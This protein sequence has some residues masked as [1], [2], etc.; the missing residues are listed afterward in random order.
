MDSALTDFL[1]SR[2]I[3]ARQ[4]EEDFL[5]R[6]EAAARQLAEQQQQEQSAGGYGVPNS[7]AASRR[8][9]TRNAS[10]TATATTPAAG[11]RRAAAKKKTA[12]Q[13]KK[14]KAEMKRKFYESDGDDDDDDD[15]DDDL[16][17]ALL[18]NVNTPLPGQM[19]NCAQCGKRFTVTPYSRADASGKLLC[20]PCGKEL[21]KADAANGAKGG[22]P[23]KKP[24]PAA[25][26]GPV[27]QR[28][29]AQSRLLDG[30]SPVG[31]KALVTLCVEHLSRN[32]DLADN[33][34]DLPEEVVDS[35]ARMLSKRRLLNPRTI[36]LFA[37][38][39]TTVLRVYDGAD[40]L[41]NDFMRIL[42][43]MPRLKSLTVYNAI[44][45]KDPVMDYLLT[46]DL[47]LDTLCLYGANLLSDAKWKQ[48]LVERGRHLRTLT[49]C[50]T[51]KHLTDEV[52]QYVRDCA[53]E[54]TKLKICGNEQVSG[55]GV[56][57]MG[58]LPHLQHLSLR[59]LKPVHADVFVALLLRNGA[60]LQTLSLREVGEGL[61]NAVLMAIHERCRA[62]RKLRLTETANRA[63]DA[64]FARLFED[65]ENPPLHVLDVE[66]N[67]FCDPDQARD[68]PDGIGFCSE[69][70]RA[71]MAH[72]G[73]ELQRLNIYACRH[74]NQA[75]FEEVFAAGKVYPA[76]TRIE[77][78]FCEELTD[79]IVG[80]MFRCC[81]SLRE[82]VTF[83]CM[84]VTG[85]QVP[86]GR[87][88]VGV[89]NALGMQTVGHEDL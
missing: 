17:R 74:I 49:I 29:K 87:V 86:H 15:D 2:N 43:V 81:P 40:L 12:E 83:G 57:Y 62:L 56:A 55:V 80:C 66:K 14:M 76:L 89:P 46:R 85:T 44:Q 23:K 21:D 13:I 51:D 36:D 61:D 8:S 54:L 79:Y 26:S 70:F 7:A 52:I 24:R 53:P 69:A 45:F 38:P 32:I 64:G 3:S 50:N 6:R 4:I 67:R 31:A 10:S 20:T 35:I 75:A 60:Q 47:Q 63:T 33:L 88:V 16:T 34:G 5:A 84:R 25:A 28:R 59:L 58:Q 19:D 9:S 65:W 77:A 22:L 48:F 73:A 39:D 11:K 37:R 30:A 1:A 78:S 41:E 68:N 27:G 18:N 82:V 72:S 71:L 42:Q